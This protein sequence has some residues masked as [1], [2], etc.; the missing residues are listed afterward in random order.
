MMLDVLDESNAKQG[1]LVFLPLT[2][3]GD[4]GGHEIDLTLGHVYRN[5][6]IYVLYVSSLLSIAESLKL[7]AHE[8]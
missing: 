7:I 6:E 3:N 4:W 5:S 8:L 1:W 2:Y